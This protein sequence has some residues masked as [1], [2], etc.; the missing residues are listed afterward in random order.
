MPNCRPAIDV[1][2]RVNYNGEMAG[3][4]QTAIKCGISIG[5]VNPDLTE[6]STDVAAQVS[7]ELKVGT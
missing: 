3:V 7:S 6:V 2:P 1:K 5:E 4:A